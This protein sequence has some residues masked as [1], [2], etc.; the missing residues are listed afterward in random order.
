MTRKAVPYPEMIMQVGERIAQRSKDEFIQTQ[1][2][3]YRNEEQEKQS[4]DRKQE[5]EMR[6]KELEQIEKRLETLEMK[7]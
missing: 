6:N 1:V 3:L 4:G 5:T 7:R 2:V